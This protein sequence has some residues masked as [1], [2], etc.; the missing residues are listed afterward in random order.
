M[1]VDAIVCRNNRMTAIL[2]MRDVLG[3]EGAWMEANARNHAWNACAIIKDLKY[4]YFERK[5]M[6]R[7]VVEKMKGDW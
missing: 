6:Q 5:W 2:L 1:V 3:D 4:L 7:K